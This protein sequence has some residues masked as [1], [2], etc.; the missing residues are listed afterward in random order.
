MKLN[1]LE[2]LQNEEECR[3]G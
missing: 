3:T 1:L 2:T